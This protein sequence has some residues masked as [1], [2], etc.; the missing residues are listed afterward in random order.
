MS[1]IK[2]ETDVNQLDIILLDSA[3]IVRVVEVIIEIELSGINI[4]ATKGV[5]WFVVA[6][7]SPT[8]L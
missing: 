6:K 1:R 5:S 8:R 4:A 3:R 2:N 7:Y